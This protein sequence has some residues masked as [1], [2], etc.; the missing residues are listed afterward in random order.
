MRRLTT[1]V[2]AVA[3]VLLGYH[4]HRPVGLQPEYQLCDVESPAPHNP[5]PLAQHQCHDNGLLDVNPD[6]RHPIYHLVACAEEEWAAKQR[7]AS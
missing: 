5:P 7:R 3:L 6:G 4:L 1:L 2:S